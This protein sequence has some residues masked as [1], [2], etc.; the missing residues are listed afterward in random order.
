MAARS[1]LLYLAR[2]IPVPISSSN[3]LRTYNWLLHLSQRFD[4]TFV[5][6]PKRMPP[7]ESLEAVQPY[8]ADLQVIEPLG[9][10]RNFVERSTAEIR[11]LLQGVPPEASRL[12]RRSTQR[13]L[14]ELAAT[15]EFSIVFAERWTWGRN[16]LALGR[17]SVVDAGFLQAE[18]H[19][20]ALRSERQPLRRILR[21]HVARAFAAAERDTLHHAD[22][23]LTQSATERQAVRDIGCQSTLFVPAGL[24]P[25]Y[26]APRRQVV[27]PSCVAFYGALDSPAQR[28]ALLHL[29]RDIM[30]EV[31]RRVRRAHLRVLSPK[32]PMELDGTRGPALQFTGPLDDPRTALWPAAVAA[33]PLRF[34]SGS[35][36]RLAQLLA[37]G[38]PVVATPS[39][40]SGLELVSG[41]G[42]LVA[43]PGTEFARTLA[44]VLQD[45]TLREDLSR[46]GRATA[47]RRLSIAATYGRFV[48]DLAAQVA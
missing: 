31:R 27:D 8:C 38:I 37:L 43:A 3:R 2:E 13:R 19:G 4:V 12:R 30:P 22:L 39:A 10:G 7:V 36:S 46:R 48:Q 5:C 11:Y 1:S 20:L 45:P 18:P 9:R 41:D 34:G 15:R 44:D 6:A 32:I 28:D 23:V 25:Q 33:I 35:R 24:D 40:V 42:V 14:A 47:E 29:H 26:F 21:S 17:F 16:A